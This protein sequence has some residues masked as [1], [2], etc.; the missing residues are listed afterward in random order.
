MKPLLRLA[1]LSLASLLVAC[2]SSSAEAKRR[3]V[4]RLLHEGKYAR[5]LEQAER[6]YRKNPSD[7]GAREDYRLASAAVL[8]EQGRRWLFEDRNEEALD[9]FLQAKAIAPEQPVIDD[10]VHNAS[11]K[12]ALL[13]HRQG[14]IAQ[15]D[16]DLEGARLSFEQSLA[17]MPSLERARVAL[18]RTLLQLNYREGMGKEYYDEG[19]RDLHEHLL[20]EADFGFSAS[21]KYAPESERAEERRELTRGQLAEERS[22]LAY[23]LEYDGAFAAARNEFRMALLLDEGNAE[24]QAGFERTQR[25]EQAAE[26]LREADRRILRKEYDLARAALAEGRAYT[27]RQLEDFDDMERALEE[28]VLGDRYTLAR[29]LES[30]QQFEAAAAA[31]AELLELAPY[32]RDAIARK[33]TLDSYVAS[34]AEYYAQ[35]LAQEDPAE[36]AGYLR[37]IAVF[38]PDYRDVQ[39]RLAALEA[40]LLEEARE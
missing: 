30:D 2:Q 22:T 20:D 5:A 29:T 26:F 7:E 24:A 34:A 4:S 12:L 10:W 23:Q 1:S 33:D 28:A 14:M 16:G 31:Y 6:A 17:Y 25:E 8:L 35:A 19:V 9:S 11:E 40:E 36:Q 21:L 13:C 18:A 27:E 32:F 39:E 37:R 38:W 3:D 15:A